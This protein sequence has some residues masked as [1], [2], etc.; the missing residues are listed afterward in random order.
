MDSL[1][2]RCKELESLLRDTKSTVNIDGL[3]D[4]VSALVL[5]C[6]PIRKNKNVESFLNRCKLP[7]KT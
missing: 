7:D 3:L 1:L 4:S 6:E 5:D 2:K